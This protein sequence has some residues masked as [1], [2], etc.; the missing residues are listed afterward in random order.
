MQKI[1]IFGQYKTGTTGLFYKIKNSLPPSTRT[2]HE[3]PRFT[4]QSGDKKRPILAK[5]ILGRPDSSH[6]VDYDSFMHFNRKIYLVRDPRD[7]IVSGLLFMIQHQPKLRQNLPAMRQILDLLRQKETNP[8]ALSVRRILHGIL[9]LGSEQTIDEL[10]SWIV[11]QHRWLF[12][13]EDRLPFHHRQRYEDFVQGEMDDLAQYLALRLTGDA[14]VEKEHDHVPRTLGSG[15]WKNWFLDED[16]EC[17]RPLLR[18]YMARY[19]YPDDWETNATRTIRPE[20]CSQYVERT[21]LKKWNRPH[22]IS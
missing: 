21:C 9:S 18:P 4:A 15:D 22:E 5:V 8:T 10:L 17:F 7:W 6:A 16:I 2:L 11:L 19:G 1:A 12:E 3:E 14:V 20:H 13:F